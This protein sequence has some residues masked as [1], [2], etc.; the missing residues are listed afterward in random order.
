MILYRFLGVHSLSSAMV[1]VLGK[2][3]I[4]LLFYLF[5]LFHETNKR[6]MSLK[7]T[8]C[9]NISKQRHTLSAKFVNIVHN[10]FHETMSNLYHNFYI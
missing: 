6:Y 5:L 7:R 8:C 10:N 1:N 3:T 2:V 4:Y 9:H